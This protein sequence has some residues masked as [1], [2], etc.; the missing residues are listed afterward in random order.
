MGH[1]PRPLLVVVAALLAL[2]VVGGFVIG[3]M[4]SLK[5]GAGDD[6]DTAA[7]DGAPASTPRALP[8]AAPPPTEA[9]PGAPPSPTPSPQPKLPA[10]LPPV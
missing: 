3:L 6:D 7:S 1:V 4:P 5:R 10:D 9:A 2:C 8:P